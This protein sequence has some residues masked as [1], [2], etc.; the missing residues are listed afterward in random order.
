MPK[1]CTAM[2]DSKQAIKVMD[3]FKQIEHIIVKYCINNV[4]FTNLVSSICM[5]HKGDKIEF[6]LT[7]EKAPFDYTNKEPIMRLPCKVS[8]TFGDFP[9]VLNVIN[10]EEKIGMPT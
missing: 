1:F 7:V 9:V 4:S 8:T 2:T 10:I 5:T 6:E 3:T